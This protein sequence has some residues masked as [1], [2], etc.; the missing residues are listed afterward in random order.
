MCVLPTKKNICWSWN[1]YNVLFC[2]TLP[3]ILLTLER[4]CPGI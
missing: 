3:D 2:S 1:I 4:L